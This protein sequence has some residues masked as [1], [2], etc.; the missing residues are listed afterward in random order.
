MKLLENKLRDN[1]ILGWAG[2]KLWWNK[3]RKQSKGQA[4]STNP[5]PP[6]VTAVQRRDLAIFQIQSFLQKRD[7]LHS[8]Q[9]ECEHGLAEQG[10]K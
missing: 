6:D 7:R 8:Y 10:Y 5:E 1:H 3:P 4:F 2:F 9:D